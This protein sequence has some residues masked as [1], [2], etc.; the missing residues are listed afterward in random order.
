MADPRLTGI[1]LVGGRSRRFGSPKALARYRGE[2]LADRAW[3]L[4]D[5]ACDQR[6]AV[7]DGGGLSF[8]TIPDAVEDGG[9]LAGIVAGLRAARH[10]IAVVV[11][12][13]APLL[14]AAALRE[15]AAGCRDA[16][17]PQTGPLPCA[18]AARV[19][20]ELEAALTRGELALRRAFA[21]LDTARVEL[22]PAVLANVNTRAELE[23][24]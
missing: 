22:D 7:G 10:E 13:D 19:L 12:V 8:E 20:P 14:T 9:P 3:R 21:S 11:P 17:V 15:L 2:T 6:V 5:E 16:A 1:L 23:R 24:L 18:L 4:L